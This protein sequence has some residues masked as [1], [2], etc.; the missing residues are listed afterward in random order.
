MQRNKLR[1][2]QYY[3]STRE[4]SSN[5]NRPMNDENQA[6]QNGESPIPNAPPQN[7]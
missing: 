5:N 2:T 6:H 4:S 3:K 1:L 7:H